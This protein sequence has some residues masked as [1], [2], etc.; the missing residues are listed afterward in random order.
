MCSLY[1][2]VM[3]YCPYPTGHPEV[4][5]KDFK[6][7][8]EYF[9]VIKCKILPPR[10]LYHPVLPVS[11]DKKLMFPLCYS[12]AKNRMVNCIHSEIERSFVGTWV[13]E[14]VKKA[15][16]KGY[17]ILEIYEVCHYNEKALYDPH[18]Q[19]GGLFSEYISTFQG[20]KQEASG[21]PE[22]ITDEKKR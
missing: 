8:H 15:I 7:V 20:Y 10:C 19:Q 2:W 21:W 6:D 1:P 11:V 4:I 14:E 5:L 13:T 9:G 22:W 16:E 18:T 12:C 3:K 17:T